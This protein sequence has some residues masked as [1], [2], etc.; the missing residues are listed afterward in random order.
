M[1]A[2]KVI[3]A[4]GY[5]DSPNFVT[6]SEFTWGRLGSFAH[7]LRKAGAELS[8]SG[9]Y[10]LKGPGPAIPLVYVCHVDDEKRVSEIHK[11]VWN[12]D[13]VPYLI[14]SSPAG[15]RVFSGFDYSPGGNKDSHG[16]L[17]RLVKPDDIASQLSSFSAK[18][19]DS[20]ATWNRYSSKITPTTRLNA[21]LLD[22]LK[23]LD[24]H[25]Q[26]QELPR[27]SSHAL[28]GKFVYLH[29]LRDRG[30]LSDKKLERWGLRSEQV[31]G[32]QATLSGFRE[33]C[34][35][36][37]QWLNGRIFPIDF[38]QKSGIKSHHIKWVSGIFAGEDITS[39]G[40]RQLHLDFPAYDFSFIPVET[41][42]VV[43]EQFLHDAPDKSTQTRGSETRAYYTP[44]PVVNLM[45]S[46]L[47]SDLPLKRGMRVFDPTCG[48]GAFL[49]QCYRKL[50]EREFPPGT[51]P[52]PGQL[53]ELLQESIFG[54]DLD[55]D[56][57][58][59][60]E[61][62]LILTL[63][64]YIN[65]PDLEP[66]LHNFKLP[67]LRGQ[68]IVEG[69][70]FSSPGPSRAKDQTYDWVVGNPPWKKISLTRPGRTFAEAAS[71]IKK[72]S[73]THPV[74]N[75]EVARAIAWKAEEHLAPTGRA[76]LLLPAMTL[77]ETAAKTFREKF[78]SHFDVSTVANFSN[79]AEVLA[80]GRFR[81]PSAAVFFKHRVE[82]HPP[83]S[84]RVFSPLVAN[85]E[86]TRPRKP[87]SRIESWVLTIDSSDVREL[88]MASVANGESLPWK[89]AAWGCPGDAALLNRL[90]SSFPKLGELEGETFQISEGL[91]NRTW[92]DKEP[93]D[94]IP[95]IAGAKTLDTKSLAKWR[96]LFRFE[97]RFLK[98]I[99]KEE[100][101]VRKGRATLPLSVCRPP[102]VILSAARNFAV[103]SNEF[104]VVPAR[105]IGIVSP[106]D[107]TLLLK[108]LALF[109][110][111][112]FARY[113]EFLS[114]SQLGVQ[115]YVSTL[116][117]VRALPIPLV[118]LSRSELKI[119]ADLHDKLAKTPPARLNNTEDDLDF[120]NNSSR[121]PAEPLLEE[122]NRLTAE[123]LGLTKRDQNL[124][125]SLI[126]TRIH[127]NDGRVGDEAVKAPSKKDLRDYARALKADLDEFLGLS[128]G[129]GHE[130][131]IT[132]TD[133]AGLLRI[134]RATSE[135]IRG[136]I[137]ICDSVEPEDTEAAATL[138][139]LR[140][141][142]PQ[143]VYFRRSLRYYHKDRTYL[144][145]PLQR[146]QWTVA[147]ATM[148]AASVIADHITKG[149]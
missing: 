98:T 118:K 49:V 15:I 51:T 120:S 84:V 88:P 48:S 92:S 144:L 10:T 75:N 8:L 96:R 67:D 2:T 17:Q 72:Y 112:D 125:R 78:I 131:T 135:P 90:S 26:A 79:L 85:Q 9:A 27:E 25:L 35:K 114:S 47:D 59:V 82:G 81:V 87:G 99:P 66:P 50:I 44:L 4:L 32:S 136:G 14:V 71:W 13:V 18:S 62:S 126:E 36:L 22:N 147:Q 65:P 94:E 102:H 140:K 111:S 83:E 11:L 30:I 148:D 149:P 91:Q 16:V 56:A 127:L 31:F 38:S 113:H 73:K 28:I 121:E 103:F 12:Q 133:Q 6:E 68:N 21:R 7:V 137:Q 132:L 124:I 74:G 141:I 23:S 58:S 101:W 129:S 64:D 108:A 41:L 115:R 37:D 54:I 43:Y 146:F 33:V 61:L 106:T 46:Q 143:W 29:Y 76:A 45:L 104:L 123:A 63:L 42:S 145:K 53:R 70:F 93:L 60:A 116:N 109:L 77:F 117:A 122:L 89:I 138:I 1:S 97:D 105:Q 107:D 24:A 55:P 100:R 69:D 134:A 20:G 86:V 80:G 3:S 110:S 34:A 57:C 19:I 40:S 139:H 95:E 130:I 39:D 5:H 52:K 142:E 119:W 128:S